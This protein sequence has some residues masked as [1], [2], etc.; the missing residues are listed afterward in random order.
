M[1]TIG[2]EAKFQY[3]AF[4][5]SLK[6]GGSVLLES[7]LQTLLC[8]VCAERKNADALPSTALSSRAQQCHRSGSF[9]SAELYFKNKNLGD[10]IS[11]YT[12][13]KDGIF[14][15]QTKQ[16]GKILTSWNSAANQHIFVKVDFLTRVCNA[17]CLRSRV[18]KTIVL[19]QWHQFCFFSI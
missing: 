9:L 4:F 11:R 5:Y 17:A 10:L 14:G 18:T 19:T 6:K 15:K 7:K 16:I 8:N 13:T 3:T 2:C 12:H 1:A